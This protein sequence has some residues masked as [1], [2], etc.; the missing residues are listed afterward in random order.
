MPLA[1]QPNEQKNKNVGITKI[2]YSLKCC[3]VGTSTDSWARLLV[4]KDRL[5][6]IQLA[7]KLTPHTQNHILKP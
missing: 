7:V 1:T 3:P 5:T 2:K 6:D 4:I